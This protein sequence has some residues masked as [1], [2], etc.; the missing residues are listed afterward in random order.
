MK[1]VIERAKLNDDL[2]CTAI[3]MLKDFQSAVDKGIQSHTA[4]SLAGLNDDNSTELDGD[5]IIIPASGIARAALNEVGLS[6][7]YGSI[8]T[9]L[10]REAIKGV[11]DKRKGNERRIGSINPQPTDEFKATLPAW[12]FRPPEPY[13]Q[14]L[15]QLAYISP[16]FFEHLHEISSE[17]KRYLRRKAGQVAVWR[18]TGQLDFGH[19][20]TLWGVTFRTPCCLCSE[21]GLAALLWLYTGG[22]AKVLCRAHA[23]AEI[24]EYTAGWH[25][26]AHEATEWLDT[27]RAGLPA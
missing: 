4:F 27:L 26:I 6:T 9:F 23:K 5:P 2:H 24:K 11:N 13:P 15:A 22:P 3:E 17:D 21:N 18:I 14:R 20:L 12:I 10:I 8:D 19:L 25:E 7:V 16:R 1:D